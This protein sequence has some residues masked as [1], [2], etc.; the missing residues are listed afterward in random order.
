MENYLKPYKWMCLNE[1]VERSNNSQQQT[2]HLIQQMFMFHPQMVEVTLPFL[3]N[4]LPFSVHGKTQQ[5]WGLKKKKSKSKGK[6][7]LLGKNS[8]LGLL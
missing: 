7:L 8:P 6:G 1:V 4:L 5:E 2:G 3:I